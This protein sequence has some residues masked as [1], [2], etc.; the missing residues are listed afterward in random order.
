MNLGKTWSE[1]FASPQCHP[2]TLLSVATARA[3]FRATTTD[4]SSIVDPCPPVL[5]YDRYRILIRWRDDIK[6]RQGEIE[7]EQTGG[8][9]REIPRATAT[10]A[11]KKIVRS[12]SPLFCADSRRHR[13]RAAITV[14]F[15]GLCFPELRRNAD[16]PVG[17]EYGDVSGKILYSQYFLHPETRVRLVSGV[18]IRECT[19]SQPTNLNANLSYA[20]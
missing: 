13:W 4:I 20:A 11:A 3:P 18:T 6:N 16:W 19:L 12:T 5:I 10:G 7:V 2:C 14:V 9:A 8:T 17:P 1:P 15:G